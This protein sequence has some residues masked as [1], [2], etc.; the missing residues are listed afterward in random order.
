MYDAELYRTREEVEQWKKRD[1]I[2]LFVAQLREAALLTDADL[3]GVMKGPGPFT[4][5]APTD[6]AFAN[7]YGEL[8]QER[9]ARN[10]GEAPPSFPY[11]PSP[12]WSRER[13]AARWPAACS[14]SK[15]CHPDSR[16][17]A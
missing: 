15:T 4:V 8:A 6:E 12:D 11:P 1:P 14:E 5:F 7:I 2:S 9:M 10:L 3:V 17:P 16:P 13:T